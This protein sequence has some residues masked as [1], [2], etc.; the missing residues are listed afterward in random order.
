MKLFTSVALLFIGMVNFTFYISGSHGHLQ[1]RPGMLEDWIFACLIIPCMLTPD[2][3]FISWLNKKR[4]AL[5][6][7]TNKI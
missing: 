2:I 7:P 4:R 3:F 1:F 5:L 6:N